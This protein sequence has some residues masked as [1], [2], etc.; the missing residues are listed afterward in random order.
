QPPAISVR[1]INGPTRSV[2][3][4]PAEPTLDLAPPELHTFRTSDGVE[5]QA[6]VYRPETSGRAPVIVSVYGGPSAQMVNDSWA[7]TVDLRAQMLAQNG[8][9]V[10]KV[11]NRG[12]AR[13][14]LAFEAPIARNMGDIEVRDQVAGIRWLGTLGF[15]NT[16]RAGIYGWS[17]GCT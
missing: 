4:A 15:A 1:D 10:L 8:F 9:V 2:L 5:L 12:S 7:E 17:Y 3:H 11:D 14:G 6:A 13:R 16:D